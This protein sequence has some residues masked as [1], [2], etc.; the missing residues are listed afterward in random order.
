MCAECP[1][2]LRQT[3]SALLGLELQTVVR[4]C[5]CWE[6]NLCP[7]EEQPTLL[8]TEPTLPPA[9]FVLYVIFHKILIHPFLWFFFFDWSHYIPDTEIH[10]PPASDSQVARI[11]GLYAQH[12][13]YLIL[14]LTLEDQRTWAQGPR[15]EERAGSFRPPPPL[16]SH[17]PASCLPTRRSSSR[18]WQCRWAYKACSID[19][20]GARQRR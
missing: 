12:N 1:Q 19:D 17:E 4:W 14:P 20:P 3:A 10:N 15:E 2:R 6:L 18:L 11:S 9:F 8:T 7:P 13:G 5:M 16:H